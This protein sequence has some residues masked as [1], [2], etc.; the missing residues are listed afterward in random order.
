MLGELVPRAPQV[1]VYVHVPFCFKKC[2]YCAFNTA[3]HDDEAMRR[4]VAAVRREVDIAA[5]APW[6]TSLTVASV[7]FGGGTPSLL[8]SDDLA[9]ILSGL[10][11]GFAVTPDAEVTVECNPESVTR[12]KLEAYRA[13]G[14]TRISLG[15]QSLDDAILERLGRL[16]GSIG[17]R[18]AFDA[19]RA[20]GFTNVSVDLMYGLPDQDGTGWRRTVATVLDWKPDHVSPYGL[21][22]DAGSVW[23]STGVT[24]LPPEETVVE[25]YWTLAH[26]ARD[27]GFEHYE[28]SNYARPGFRSRH[29]L[30]YWRRGEYLA[31]GPGACGCLADLRWSNVKPVARYCDDVEAGRLPI[32]T[33]ERLDARQQL[34]ERLILGL[35]TSDGI[36]ATW[37]GE[38]V[39]GDARLAERVAAWRTSGWLIDDGDRVRLTESGFLVSDGLFVDLL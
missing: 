10:R 4:Y 32:D 39:A 18:R 24:G 2:Y 13:A 34:A 28:I 33:S 25:Q 16:H 21:S 6:G 8:A 15:V 20:A 36:P 23:G 1:G 12:S 14:V 3:P 35:R 31:F 9:A 17:A 37:L 30:T 11:R 19:A 29:N 7:F 22:L 5:T 26:E 38:R 27:R